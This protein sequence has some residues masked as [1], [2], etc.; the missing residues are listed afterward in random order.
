[1]LRIIDKWNLFFKRRVTRTRGGVQQAK[2]D[3]L[4]MLDADPSIPVEIFLA[5]AAKDWR[6]IWT[7]RPPL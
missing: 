4:P 3:P 7:R 5:G 6:M 2:Q 1:M